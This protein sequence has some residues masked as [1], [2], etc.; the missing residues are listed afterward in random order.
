M[1]PRFGAQTSV[2]L[3]AADASPFFHEAGIE[4]AV[5]T[6][7]TTTFQPGASPA[8]KAFIEGTAS[9]KAS[10]KGYYD[11]TSD[12]ALV[13]NIRDGGSVLTY[14]PAGLLAV[15]DPARLLLVHEVAVAESSPIGGAVL[16]SAGF[17]GDAAVGFGWCL[18]PL[19]VDTGT[20]TGATRND[21]AASST[22]WQAHLHVTAV[23]GSPTSWTAKLQDSADG[24]T[25][26]DVAGGGFAPTN[27][28]AA[29][30]LV[31]AP[32]AALRQYVRYVATVIGGTAPT[33]T[34]GL[35]YAR[36]R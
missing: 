17:T 1:A 23:T 3:D 8:W 31:S 9:A 22:G 11:Q 32:G 34:F 28:P 18:H 25:W 2:W 35:A 5:E 4:V 33:V 20:T 24:A 10:L 7:E 36:N 29:Q 21:G 15:G 12:A 13:A 19:S 27:T 30:R 6:A 14:G 16:A 26:A